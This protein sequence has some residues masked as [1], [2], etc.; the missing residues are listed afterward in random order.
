[1]TR[2]NRI[3]VVDDDPQCAAAQRMILAS[4]GLEDIAVVR[5]AAAA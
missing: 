3:L 1:M 2:S 5:S 4:G